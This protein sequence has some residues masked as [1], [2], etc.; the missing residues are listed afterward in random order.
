MAHLAAFERRAAAVNEHRPAAVAAVLLP[1]ADG[2][3][4]LLLTRRAATL[5]SH[6]RQW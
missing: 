2:R 4:C 3:A 6:T 1:D 5:R